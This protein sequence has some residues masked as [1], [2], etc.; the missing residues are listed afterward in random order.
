MP[1][2]HSKVDP[3]RRRLMQRVRRADTD[4]EIRVR[5]ALHAMGLRFRLHRKSLPGTPDI[6]LPGRQLALFVHGCFWHQHPGCSR[7]TM[8]K[9]R[10]GFWRA[11]FEANATRDARKSAQLRELGWRVET[12]WECEATDPDQLHSIL[13]VLLSG[14]ER[15]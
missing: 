13:S 2:E 15:C 10:L 1:T 6:V 7:A 12:I 8:P 3:K 14:S 5:R 9:S 11:K 4:P